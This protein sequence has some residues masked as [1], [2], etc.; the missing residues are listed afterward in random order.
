[1]S[2]FPED[3]IRR[4]Q[5]LVNSLIQANAEKATQIGDMNRALFAANEEVRRLRLALERY[6]KHDY[7]CDM[8]PGEFTDCIC[9]LWEAK[10]LEVAPPD[11]PGDRDEFWRRSTK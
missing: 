8:Q 10:G 5:D 4:L 7:V 11:A 6:G 1:M 2:D 3:K 9:G